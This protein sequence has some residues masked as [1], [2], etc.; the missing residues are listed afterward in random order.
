[1]P[2]IQ[3]H[4]LLKKVAVLMGGKSAERDISL[5]SGQ[6]VLNALQEKGINAYA[7]DPAL[8]SIDELQKAEFSSAFIALHGRFGEDGIMQSILEHLAIPYTGSGV[9]ASSVA[10]N[11]DMTKR[12]WQT[13]HLATPNFVILND[14][15]NGQMVIDKLGLP[16][17]VKPGREGSSLGLS[18]VHTLQELE[19]AYQHAKKYDNLVLAEQMI[20]GRE[21]TCAVLQKNG[22]AQTLPV[23]EIKAPQGEYDYNNKYFTDDVQYLCPAPISAD[24]TQKIQELTLQAFKTLGCHGWARADLMI[25]QNNQPYLLEINTSPGM[26]SH[27][28]VPMA[29]NALGIS[30]ADLVLEILL[31]AR[32]DYK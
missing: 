20:Q 8:Q 18:K 16:I 28:L 10:I 22:I 9:M 3:N 5:M 24:L 7:F 12:I 31:H 27:S 26:T 13:Y 32:L 1:M 2:N 4:P 17:I 30:Y 21:V 15:T 11:K 25:D 6:G 19:I 29:A 23:I 14:D